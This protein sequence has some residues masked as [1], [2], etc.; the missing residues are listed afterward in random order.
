[1][2]S[3]RGF[4]KQAA[5]AAG[6]AAI[7][8][9]IPAGLLG[10]SHPNSRIQIGCVGVGWQGGGN[11]DGF[12]HQPDTR[13]VAVCDVDLNHLHGARDRVNRHYGDKSCATF[14]DYRELLAREDIDAVCL[15]LPD[16]WHGIIAV[17]AAVA[18]KDIYGEKPLAY[19]VTEGRA[20]VDAVERNGVIW[21]TGSWQRSQGNFRYGCELVRNGCI[22]NIQRIEV[23][24]PSGHA[25]FA[26]NK[27]LVDPVDPPGHLDYNAWLGPAPFE[28]YCPARVHKNWRWNLDYG[29]GQLTD[30]IG[31]HN[32]IAHWGMDFDNQ[33][34][35][36]IEGEGEY[37]AEGLW[38]TA[39]RYR[40]EA[41][42]P[43]GLKSIIAGG[44]GDIAGGTRWIG[45]AGWVRVDRDNTLEASD[46]KI[47]KIRFKP[48]DVHLYRSPG[49]IREFLDSVK[50]RRET[51]TPVR[52]A[53]YS[54][55]PGYL[56]QIAMLTGRKIRWNDQQ[57]RIV[58]DP[59]AERL[60]SRSMR[61][62]YQ[63]YV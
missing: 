19:N 18:G 36:S 24:L 40:L 63:L 37:P 52:T 55:L 4:L 1:M 44:H 13:V 9:I 32:D 23:G 58:D 56:G 12:L 33:A 42:Y 39:R 62:P 35:E 29:G 14:T 27:D 20:I 7:P 8:T 57:H 41:T 48:G 10:R 21:Q 51:L 46:A 61:S 38:N 30:W 25:D 16:H 15:S 17:A 34:I 3:R 50:T 22:G 54:A 6:G 59:A 47:L 60:L 45:D 2:I 26:N 53:Y 31:H 28:P 43:G 49:H 5:A 11:M